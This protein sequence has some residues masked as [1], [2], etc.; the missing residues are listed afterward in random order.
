MRTYRNHNDVVTILTSQ[1]KNSKCTLIF[2]EEI[3]CN[4]EKQGKRYGLKEKN[5]R[6]KL[7]VKF[8]SSYTLHVTDISAY[9]LR[10]ELLQGKYRNQH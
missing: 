10:S 9:T 1:G 2:L 3:Q 4:A 7:Q 5:Q 6:T 8:M